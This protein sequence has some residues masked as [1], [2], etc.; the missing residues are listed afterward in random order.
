[1]RS[2]PQEIQKK[3]TFY[4]VKSSKGKLTLRLPPVSF[5]HLMKARRA[6]MLNMKAIPTPHII[7]LYCTSHVIKFLLLFGRDIDFTSEKRMVQNII[8]ECNRYL[9]NINTYIYIQKATAHSSS[10]NLPLTLLLPSQPAWVSFKV[11][12]SVLSVGMVCGVRWW[13]GPVSA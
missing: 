2:L 4:F 12:V 13:C 7:R 9:Y 5:H 3:K 8:Y 11:S 6:F 1:M 10:P